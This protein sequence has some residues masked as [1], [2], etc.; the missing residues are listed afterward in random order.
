MAEVRPKQ[1]V[2]LK[3][4]ILL[5]VV[6]VL[7]IILDRAL[8]ASP[9]YFPLCT[10]A[11]WLLCMATF[12]AFNWNKLK[13]NVFLWILCGLFLLLC[14]TEMRFQSGLFVNKYAT[15]TLLVIPV[16]F[17]AH[18]Q[19]CYGG[20]KL[21]DAGVIAREFLHG[22]FAKPFKSADQL[23]A[24]IASFFRRSER[25]KAFKVLIGVSVSI[26]LLAVVVPLMAG[27]DLAFRYYLVELIRGF[28]LLDS[29][30]HI[31]VILAFLLFGYSFFWN[32]SFG[33]PM[34]RTKRPKP[35]YESM[36]ACIILGVMVVSY[37]VFCGMQYG[38]MISGGGL[39][40]GITYSEYAREGF[41][42]LVAI[43]SINLILFGV[44]FQYF[45]PGKIVS[46]LRYAL[47][48]LTMALL[49]SSF[50]RLGLY[51]EAYGMTWLRLLSA[52]FII[53]LAVVLIMCVVRTF[54]HK[55][56]LITLS[57]VFLLAWYVVLG[58]I[59]PVEFIANFNVPGLGL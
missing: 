6:F 32:V 34:Q 14:A 57:A 2:T 45:K 48:A 17:L 8:F 25:N 13:N 37:A 39:P 47:L 24:T 12:C 38:Y 58:L 9:E 35:E 15:L 4:R 28:N 20:H 23:F 40:D 36:I 7:A 50:I 51:I 46:W 43:S 11:F 30:V 49:V 19:I 56:P 21:K 53:Y 10:S 59:N 26:G 44:C 5:A 3:E 29:R 18:T 22:L 52:W 33:E 1:K 42:Q 55:M 31:F 41:W 27:A 54:V 16:V